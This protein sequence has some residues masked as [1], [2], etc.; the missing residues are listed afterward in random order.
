MIHSVKP[1]LIRSTYNTLPQGGPI[2][3]KFIFSLE[4]S[5]WMWKARLSGYQNCW[6]ILEGQAEDEEKGP[7]QSIKDKLERELDQAAPDIQISELIVYLN[8]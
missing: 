3:E 4:I 5:F 1:G 7:I 6:V 2:S 8:Q